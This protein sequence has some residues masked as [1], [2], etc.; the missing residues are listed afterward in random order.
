MTAS[1]QPFPVSSRR[2]A[3]QSS[4]QLMFVRISSNLPPVKTVEE[5]E[6]R[7]GGVARR[8]SDRRLDCVQRQLTP[9]TPATLAQLQ[10]QSRI[11]LLVSSDL[12]RAPGSNCVAIRFSRM[13]WRSTPS[14]GGAGR[15]SSSSAE[16]TGKPRGPRASH[17]VWTSGGRETPI[18]ETRLSRRGRSPPTRNGPPNSPPSSCRG[19]NA[20]GFLSAAKRLRPWQHPRGFA[21]RAADGRRAREE[22]AAREFPP[23]AVVDRRRGAAGDVGPRP[24]PA[25]RRGRG[26]GDA[27]EADSH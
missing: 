14:G 11:P 25:A 23:F 19:C 8:L 24:L 21:P 6:A 20:A 13:P 9:R 17:H 3:A 22:M 7:V 12:E 5:D 26:G 27:V 2:P 4:P 10:R 18:R 1:E 15:R 16:L